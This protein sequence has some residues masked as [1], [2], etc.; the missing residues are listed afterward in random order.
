MKTITAHD[1]AL[2]Q[3]LLPTAAALTCAVADNNR[4]EVRRLLASVDPRTLPT[5]TVLLAA[6]V[7]P[8]KPF[9]PNVM[10]TDAP[11]VP[12]VRAAGIRF[13]I[14]E[15][16]IRSAARSRTV[17]DARSVACYAARL[18]GMT[19]TDIGTYVRRDH[20]TVLYAC[21]RVGESAHLRRTAN[22][23]LLDLGYD[24]SVEHQEVLAS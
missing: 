13:L 24:R 21:T 22:A 17:V 15:A 2:V 9:R 5:L 6:H 10:H 19:L 11:I 8:E 3:S 18:A 1:V 12:I 20:S 16:Q 23:I 14:P 4:V 7:D